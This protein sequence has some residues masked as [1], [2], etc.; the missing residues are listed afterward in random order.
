MKKQFDF[1]KSGGFV[2]G[3]LRCVLAAVM[4][5]V[6]LGWVLPMF[7][8]LLYNGTAGNIPAS[9]V[10][11]ESIMGQY[12]AYIQ[13]CLDASLENLE[14][15]RWIY[16]LND[17]DLIAPEPNP[18]CFGTADDPSSLG[19]LLEAARET[20]GVETVV[21]STDTRIMEGSEIRYYLDDSIFVVTWKQI[22]NRC[23]YSMSEV[24]VAHPSQFRRYVSDGVYGSESLYY[25]S[26]MAA[27]VNAVTAA[28]GDFYMQRSWGVSIYMGQVQ[29][30][31]TKVDTCYI[32]GNGDMIFTRAGEIRTEEEAQAFADAHDVR[33]SLAFGPVLVENGVNVVPS[34]YPLGEINDRYARA[35][36]C[37][38]GE[39]HYL[40]VAA[41]QQGEYKGL[42]TSSGFA[43]EL[44]KLG[45]Q[46]A[47]SIDGGQSAAIVTGDRLINRPVYGVQRA[48][49][50]IIY[51]ATAIPEERW[52]EE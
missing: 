48:M 4:A 20:L 7:G 15:I 31:S 5:A 29:N 26:A 21:F 30:V 34:S 10:L 37:Q 33:F 24:K 13:Q 6:T 47:F 8:P 38:L 52:N 50:D 51:F 27:T 22:V 3:T 9:P 18:A 19:W 17:E 44:V 1:R 49:S 45:A 42:V 46:K 16:E 14:P 41:N 40:L 28:N 43:D 25:P 12:D 23:V 11:Q 35:A 32:D 2:R 36:L 39:L